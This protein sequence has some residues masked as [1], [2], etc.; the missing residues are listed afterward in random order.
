MAASPVVDEVP[1]GETPDEATVELHDAPNEP[2]PRHFTQDPDETLMMIR[3]QYQEALYMSQV[4]THWA[5][6]HCVQV[7]LIKQGIPRIL[8]KRTTIT[9]PSLVQ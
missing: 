5:I 3:T 6:F 9:S 1:R 4:R 7:M 8:R 2:L